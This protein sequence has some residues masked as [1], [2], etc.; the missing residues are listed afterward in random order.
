MADPASVALLEDLCLSAWPAQRQLYHRGWVLRFAG[1]H[2][3]RAN[4]VTAIGPAAELGA[5]FID[6]CNAAYRQQGLVPR[7]RLTPLCPPDLEAQLVAAG[8]QVREESLVMA[9][10]VPPPHPADAAV[11]FQPA[12]D[13][14]WLTAYRSMVAIPEAEMPALRAIL[15]GIAPTTQYATLWSDGRPVAAALAVIDRG[16]VGLYKVASHPRARG[17]GHGRRLVA[18]LLSMAASQGATKA[19]LQVGAENAPALALYA[20]F[21][22][23]TVYRYRYAVLS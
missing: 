4:A 17:Q 21:G 1:G 12:V 13:E 10:A 7:F 18:A 23:E 20:R 2:S 19:Y 6:W 22:F 3:G 11:R 14:A 15:A 5:G 9:A 16:W 8:Y